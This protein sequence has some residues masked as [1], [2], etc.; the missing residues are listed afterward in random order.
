[1]GGLVWVLIFLQN[2]DLSG[3]WTVFGQSLTSHLLLLFL[4]GFGNSFRV[5]FGQFYLILG[6]I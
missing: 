3:I 1:M 5:V 4:G 2:S 6:S